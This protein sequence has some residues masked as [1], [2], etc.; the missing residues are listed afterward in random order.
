MDTLRLDLKVF[1]NKIKNFIQE[2][3]P[4]GKIDFV[5][6]TI[7]SCESP[8]VLACKRFAERRHFPVTLKQKAVIL[9]L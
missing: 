8:F 9:N 5:T 1:V 3:M 6:D 2:S 7:L 4:N